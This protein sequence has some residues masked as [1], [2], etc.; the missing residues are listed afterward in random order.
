VHGQEIL[1]IIFQE[2]IMLDIHYAMYQVLP[3]N[4]PTMNYSNISIIIS[5]TE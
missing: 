5:N 4:L 2:L 3:S 1:W